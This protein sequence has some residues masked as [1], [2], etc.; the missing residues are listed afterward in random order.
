MRLLL[1][2]AVSAAL[3]TPFAASA[4][5]DPTPGTPRVPSAPAGAVPARRPPSP[6]AA[7]VAAAMDHQ[8]TALAELE[9][10]L[11]AATDD[12]AARAIVRQI[13]VVKRDAEVEVLRA[14]AEHA[15]QAGRPDVARRLELAI[16]A[17]LAP[18]DAGEPT[19]RPTAART[20]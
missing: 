17:R 11:R 13:E 1:A 14:Q 7:R 2:L 9:L 6:L 15:R 20:R 18:P 4:A 12:A 16:A 19:P 5:S 10:R 8:R 3:V